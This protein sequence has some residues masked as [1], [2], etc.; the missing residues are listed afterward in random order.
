[1][2]FGLG[3][4][5]TEGGYPAGGQFIA[6]YDNLSIRLSVPEPSSLG[7]VKAGALAMLLAWSLR[8]PEARAASMRRRPRDVSPDRD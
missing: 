3:Q 5:F 1:M 7:L 6:P 8:R 2:L 4:I